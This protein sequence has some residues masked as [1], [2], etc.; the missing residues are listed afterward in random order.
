[1]DIWPRALLPE[2]TA[3]IKVM[4]MVFL[5]CQGITRSQSGW[6]EVSKGVSHGK[7]SEA[8]GTRSWRNQ[9]NPEV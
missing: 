8:W 2:G 4:V 7:K 1:M 9:T 6:K 3:S 5:D